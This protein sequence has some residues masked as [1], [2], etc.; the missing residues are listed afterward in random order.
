M[1][2]IADLTGFTLMHNI[3]VVDKDNIQFFTKSLMKSM[4]ETIC[5]LAQKYKTTDIILSGNTKYTEAIKEK[6]KNTYVKKYARE[7]PYDIK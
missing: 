2:I 1:R 3:Y 7:C 4:P 6:I 5:G